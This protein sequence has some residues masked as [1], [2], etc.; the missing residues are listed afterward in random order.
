MIDYGLLK[1]RT[2]IATASD[3]TGALMSQVCVGLF[4]EKG[5]T[6]V[7]TALSDE[8]GHV[9]MKQIRPGDYRLVAVSPGFVA[10]NAR[11][12]VTT[13]G[14][15]RKLLLHMEVGRIDTASYATLQ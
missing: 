12:R 9:E 10:L 8:D 7:A 14:P 4:T 2:I 11:L 13:R 5:H 15:A 1:V 6:L 3:P